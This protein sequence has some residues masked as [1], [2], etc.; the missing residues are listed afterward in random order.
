M[1]NQIIAI[2]GGI[3]S[4]KSVVSQVLRSMGYA[5]YDTDTVAKRL[6]N[7][8]T[9]LKQLISKTFGADVIGVDGYVN[10]P[11]LA[12]IVF[13]D[14]T[15]LKQL[16]DIVHP[17]VKTDFIAWTKSHICYKKVFIE[18]ALLYES[19]LDSVVDEIWNVVAPEEIRIE[20]VMKR[21]A[22]TAKDVKERI[23]SQ[24]KDVE[25]IT[26][27]IINNDGRHAVL[28]QLNKLLLECQRV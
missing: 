6:M 27:N 11:M 18:T 16:N 8:S 28:P 10:K 3:G 23:H 25:I 9:E 5:V 26:P 1:K 21:N 12:S 17:V 14:K 24:C 20:R 2:T 19:G 7:N 13:N 15:K 4:G 22:V